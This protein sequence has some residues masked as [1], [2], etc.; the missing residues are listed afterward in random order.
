MNYVLGGG[1]SGLLWAYYHSEYV[2]ITDQLGRALTGADPVVWLNDTFLTRQLLCDLGMRV[3]AEEGRIGYKHGAYVGPY[4]V[5]LTDNVLLKKMVPWEMLETSRAA[6]I[7][8]RVGTPSRQF[9][10]DNETLRYLDVD[11]GSVGLKLY[12]ELNGQNR[13]FYDRIREIVGGPGGVDLIGEECD[14]AC[15]HLVSTVPAPVFGRLWYKNTAWQMPRLHYCPVTFV[16]SQ[17]AP[18]WW[19]DTFIMVYDADLDSPVSR[20]GKFG[21]TYRYEFTGRPDDDTLN[22]YMPVPQGRFVNPYGR[23]IQDVKIEPPRNVT[24]LG[25]SGEWDYR[26]LIDVSLE[27]VHGRR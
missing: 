6:G 15:D 12:E 19:D 2:I 13:I 16:I 20:I 5:S 21:E 9:T 26:G 23:I 8:V 11:M 10:K 27:R 24:F 22:E 4:R 18:K 3:Q 17:I 14:Y 7:E 25:R 1:I